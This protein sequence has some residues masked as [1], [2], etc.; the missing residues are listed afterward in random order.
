[1]LRGGERFV[2]RGGHGERR[3]GSG[4]V[5]GTHTHTTEATA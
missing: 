2:W 5:G 1:L 4:H 3:E